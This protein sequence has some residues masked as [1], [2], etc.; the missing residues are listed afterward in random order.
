[1]ENAG[2]HLANDLGL[3]D[4]PE[5]EPNQPGGEQDDNDLEDERGEVRHRSVPR[6]FKRKLDSGSP[7][8]GLSRGITGSSSQKTLEDRRLGRVQPTGP[9]YSLVRPVGDKAVA[10]H[11]GDEPGSPPG[12]D[13]KRW[14]GLVH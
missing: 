7:E 6:E 13:G 14:A 5:K 2:N 11:P 3:L 10:F 1:D 9:Q 8:P 4:P 12:L